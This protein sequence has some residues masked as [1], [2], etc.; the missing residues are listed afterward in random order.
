MEITYNADADVLYIRLN[1]KKVHANEIVAD[2]SVVID[3]AED[4]SVVGIELI[5][6]SRYVENL[7]E[8]IVR[9]ATDIVPTGE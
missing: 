8:V 4:Q 6:P 9:R 5:S 7:N 2:D 3:L 1:H